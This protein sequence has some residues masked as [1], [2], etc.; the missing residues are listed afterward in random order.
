MFVGQ[1]AASPRRRQLSFVLVGALASAPIGADLGL[2][3]V[4]VMTIKAF[5]TI[6][7]I[8]ELEAQES[9]VADIEHFRVDKSL[10]IGM[11]L[12][13]LDGVLLPLVTQRLDPFHDR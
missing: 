1:G 7:P 5:A 2:A 3:L 9:E 8:K 10:A 13:D 12:D 4:G 6:S 11:L